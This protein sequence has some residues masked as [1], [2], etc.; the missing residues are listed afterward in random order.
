MT[1][2]TFLVLFVGFVNATGL[3]PTEGNL[4]AQT[5]KGVTLHKR[6]SNFV[7]IEAT[8]DKVWLGCIN[9]S[10]EEK[11]AFMVFYVLDGER[12]WKFHYRRVLKDFQCKK[13]E[14]EYRR[15]IAKAKTIRLVGIQPIE[16]SGP[17]SKD[18]EVPDRFTNV[19][20]RTIPTFVR[21]QA[22]GKCKAFIEEDCELPKN[23]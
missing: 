13:D 3:S 1:S 9:Q 16:E 21:L 22:D 15:M 5:S 4:P 20:V 10:P 12:A 11:T 6:T 14:Y 8:Q 23:Y 18:K 17:S 19:K 2:L 7:D